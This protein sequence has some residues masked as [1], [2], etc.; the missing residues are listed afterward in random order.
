MNRMFAT[1]GTEFSQFQS[2]RRIVSILLSNI[3]RNTPRFLINTLFITTGTFQNNSYS[4]IFTLGH[5]PPLVFF[6]SLNS[7]I[8]RLKAKNQKGTEKSIS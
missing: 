1:K 3:S 6:D 4:D 8:L 5:E 7:S 2:T